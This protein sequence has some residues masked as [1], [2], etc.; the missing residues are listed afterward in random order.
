MTYTVHITMKDRE[1]MKWDSV[2]N[3]PST[4]ERGLY[5]ESKGQAVWV[6]MDDIRTF[7]VVKEEAQ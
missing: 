3:E 1:T 7:T 4:V 6:N 2:T 5:F